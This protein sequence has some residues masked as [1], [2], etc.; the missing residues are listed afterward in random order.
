MSEGNKQIATLVGNPINVV[1]KQIRVGLG[2]TVH[3]GEYELGNTFY[4]GPDSKP[5]AT[6]DLVGVAASATGTLT[7]TN[8]GLG[9]TPADG[10]LQFNGVNLIT[11][12]GT[13]AN[14]TA[15]ITI[16]DGVAIGATI[17]AGGNGY[18]VGDVVTVGTIGVASVGRNV[19]FTIAGIGVT[20]QLILDNVQ[21]DFV[22]GAAGTIKFFNSSGISTDLNGT[23]AGGD[24][25][26]PTD[27]ITE[28]SDGLH[29]K[30]NHKNHGMNFD[31]NIVRISGVLPDVKPTKLAVAYD[32]ESSDPISVLDASTL[33]TLKELELEQQILDFF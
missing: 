9:Y 7:I 31:D 13:G 24:V 28:V 8:P 18:Q 16:E 23:S 30:V 2:T 12:S 19:R 5:T 6:G 27:G 11:V 32:K 3:D 10:R 14:A 1:S 21:G 20:T 15:D 22:V 25:T 26:I 4:Q 33:L 29:I 17:T